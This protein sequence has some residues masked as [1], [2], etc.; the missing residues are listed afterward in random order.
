[1]KKAVVLHGTD[2]APEH[3][4]FPWIKS[5]LESEG[6]EVW[7]P[8]LPQNHTPNRKVYNEFL[9]SQDWDFADNIV[10]GHSSGAVS[11]L[12]LLMDERCP[13][14]KLAV[15]LGV[16]AEDL[17][18]G[19]DED[20]K[21]FENLFPPNGFDFELIK[22]KASKIVFLHGSDDPYCPLDDAKYLSK[23]LDAS[24]KIIPNGHH[25]GSKFKELPQLW[26]ILKPNL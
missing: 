5:K 2:G 21:Q 12:N 8:L 3:N 4:W 6:Y 9:F 20:S 18:N 23:K 22:Q 16:W 14:I 11:V 17:P 26:E 7:I 1:M 25:L 13:K 19:Y 15:M 24:L 10:V